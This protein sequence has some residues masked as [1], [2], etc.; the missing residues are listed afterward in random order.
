VFVE[1]SP[2]PVLV[3]AIE[4]TLDDAV[5][6][7]TLRR[8]EGGRDRLLASAAEVFVRGVPVDWA[9]VFAD[10]GA[11]RVALPTYAFQHRRYWPSVRPGTGVGGDAAG[12]AGH[13]LLTTG[14]GLAGGDG[15]VFTGRLSV[16]AF[17]WLADHAMF[18]TVL[19]PGTALLELAAW[20]GRLAGCPQVQELALEVPLVLPERGGVQVQLRISGPQPDGGRTVT[21]YSRAG[22]AG[23]GDGAPDEWT[24]H[25][26]G[27]AVPGET[28][29][30]LA[31]ELAGE[32]PPPGAAPVPVAGRY[33]QLARSGYGYGPAFR[34]LTAAWRHGDEV[35]AEVR[36]PDDEHAGAAGFA[37]HPALLDAALHAVGFISAEGW[38]PG[39]AGDGQG[40]V[41]FSWTGVRMTGQGPQ[42]PQVPQ[43]PRVLRVRL[44]PAGDGAVA[45]LAADEA[46]RLVMAADRLVMRPVSAGALRTA[47]ARVR[48]SLFAV[49]WVPVTGTAAGGGRWAVLGADASR[50]AGLAAAGM[51]VSEYPDLAALAQAAAAGQPVPPV[52]VT[53]LSTLTGVAETGDEDT[54][55]VVRRVVHAAL[56]MVQGWLGRS[57]FARSVLVVVTRGAVAAGPGE[58]V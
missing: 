8:D 32:W 31:A 40:L 26:S 44:R 11:Q 42:D 7:G 36:L 50:T 56:E 35:F 22:A 6:A 39:P 49:E 57:G 17:G 45:V 25:A 18:G 12:A 3:P 52:V 13:P 54:A 15:A 2:H 58:Q 37:V 51:A 1:V 41:P 33:D 38:Q 5:I 43:G 34:G 55:G 20:A 23:D 27:V 28:E 48:E 29:Q 14:V 10:S 16:A 9:A 4:Q 47:R 19:V 46:G 53:W 21:V 24:R 30:G